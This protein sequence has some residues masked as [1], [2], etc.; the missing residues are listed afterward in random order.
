MLKLATFQTVSYGIKCHYWG[1]RL[2]SWNVR[3]EY[4]EMKRLDLVKRTFS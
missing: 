2:K 3:S 4:I 1:S